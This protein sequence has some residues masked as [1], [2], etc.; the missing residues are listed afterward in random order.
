MFILSNIGIPAVM[1]KPNV[2]VNSASVIPSTIFLITGNLSKNE[3]N[4]YLPISVEIQRL[5]I[6]PPKM[7]TPKIR[8][9]K[10]IKKEEVAINIKVGRGNSML[11]WAYK[12]VILGITKN[13]ITSITTNI[14]TK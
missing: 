9:Q 11:D 6:K 12:E 3:S 14:V 4:E 5:N 2:R 8:Y 7:P 10:L 13:I 1:S